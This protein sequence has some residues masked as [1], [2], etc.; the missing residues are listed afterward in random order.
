MYEN[1]D[2]KELNGDDFDYLGYCL[3]IKNIP[4][5]IIDEDM[6]ISVKSTRAL[7]HYLK[8]TL[9]EGTF[10]F[11]DDDNEFLRCLTRE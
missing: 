6:L 1:Y 3:Q 11:Q 8:N 4:A 9:L 5:L 10:Y 2:R 7:G